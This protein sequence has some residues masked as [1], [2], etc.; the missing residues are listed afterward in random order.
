M[1]DL[2]YHPQ[3]AEAIRL[4]NVGFRTTGEVVTQRRWK[5]S[6]GFHEVQNAYRGASLNWR[7]S[8]RRVETIWARMSG[9]RF[10]GRDLVIS[11]VEALN[12]M[13]GERTQ[14]R[15]LT[16]PVR[17]IQH[18]AQ[19]WSLRNDELAA[20]LAYGDPSFAAHLLRGVLPLRDA[21]RQD[22]AR[23]M[24]LIHETLADL[25]VDPADEGRWMRAPLPLLDGLAPLD[26]M[27]AH[28]IPGMVSV[29]ELVEQ[30][31]AN[32]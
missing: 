12:R 2:H 5:Q 11:V 19:V 10:V 28:R 29:Q 22:R 4:N 14:E 9:P 8:S 25:F 15:R 16:G 18:V 3:Q 26:Y 17:L 30:R 20:L 32:R 1:S 13:G 31:L 27:I 21:D 7:T 23:L 6:S 24:Y